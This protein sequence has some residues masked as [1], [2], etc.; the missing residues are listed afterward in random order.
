MGAYSCEMYEKIIAPSNASRPWKLAALA[1]SLLPLPAFNS[2][3]LWYLKTFKKHKI[4]KIYDL[5]IS[6][7]KMSGKPRDK[8]TK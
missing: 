1:I 3:M 4:M 7:E 2:Y 6:R 8:Y 5:S